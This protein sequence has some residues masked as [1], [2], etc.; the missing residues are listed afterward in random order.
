[1]ERE[2][3]KNDL[4][5]YLYGEMSTEE[6]LLFEREMESDPELAKEFLELKQVRKGLSHMEDKEVMEPFFLW[7][8]NGVNGWAGSFKRRSLVLFKPFIAVA[9]SLV[10]LLLVGYVTQFSI[11]YQDNQL[12]IGFNRIETISP[13]SQLTEEQV[14]NLVRN[15]IEQNNERLL[16]LIKNT[17]DKMDTRFASLETIQEKQPEYPQTANTV[18]D[19]DLQDFYQQM[20]QTNAVIMENY[21][22]NATVQQQEYF[23][24]V[25]NQFTGYLQDQR[26]EDLRLIRRS[27]VNLKENQDQQQQETQQILA[28][29]LNNVNYQNN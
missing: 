8:R 22:R 27:L 1:M 20:Q 18:T 3:L 2:N 16:T 10:I 13:A 17:E 21:L 29:L 5:A 26:Q 15:A 12:L 24:T 25:V 6:R 9:A 23:Q 14:I 7:G 4:I 28:N 19:K 11:T